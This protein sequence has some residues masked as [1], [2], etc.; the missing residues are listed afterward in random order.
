MSDVKKIRIAQVGVG[1]WGPNLLRNLMANKNCEVKAVVDLSKE[2][3]A[4]VKSVYPSVLVTDDIDSVLNDVDAV[5]IAT[6][7]NTHH[8]IVVK[9]LLTGKHVFVEKPVATTTKDMQHVTSL[10]DGLVVMAGHTFLYNAAVRYIKNMIDS[11]E[12]GDIRYI[13]C[14]RL[15][16]GRIRSDVNA[17]WNLA[18]HDVSIV[19]YWLDE[20]R[21]SSVTYHGMAYIQEGIDDV[22]FLTMEYP[23]GI[24]VNIHVGWLDPH[25]TR[26]VVVVGSKKMVV[27]DDV[28]ENKV[29]IHDK[30][31]DKVSSLGE[32]M[33]YDG[34]VFEFDN[35]SGDIVIPKIDWKEPLKVEIEHFIDC[36]QNGTKCLS[37]IGHATGVVEILERG[38]RT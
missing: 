11:G 24:L 23:N 15:N 30:G 38:N 19:Q 29:A 37:G 8:D 34:D 22:A 5:V 3:Q 7:V 36:I 33:D 6:P 4:F 21:P 35:R 2:R 28:A 12:I 32:D 25:K 26:R 27:Y 14:Q 20:A 18:P 17:L 9:A 16:L 13:Y 10:S 1:Y 31:I